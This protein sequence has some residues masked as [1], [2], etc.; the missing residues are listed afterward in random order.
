VDYSAVGIRRLAGEGEGEGEVMMHIKRWT[1]AYASVSSTTMEPMS[2]D[3]EE[4]YPGI[5]FSISQL[6]YATKKKLQGVTFRGRYA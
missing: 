6:L 1:P 3:N 5:D 4:S 2:T